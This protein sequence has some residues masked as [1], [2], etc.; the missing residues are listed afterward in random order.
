MSRRMLQNPQELKAIQSR[1]ANVEALMKAGI[2]HDPDTGR[3]YFTGYDYKT[4]YDWDQYFEAI[5]QVYMGW[6]AKYII[7]GITIFL[8]HMREDGLISRS[9]PSN[10]YHDPEHVKPFL[11]QSAVLVRDYYGETSWITDH[12]YQRLK[13]Y[14]DYW[15]VNMD[16]TS[17]GLAEWMS[18]PHTGMDNQHERAGWWKDRISKGVDLNCFLVR[19][20]RAFASLAE[21]LGE[22]ADSAHYSAKADELAQKINDL[23]WCEEDGLYYDMN[24]Q[25]GALTKVKYINNFAALW[26]NVATPERAKRMV[27]EHLMNGEE[28][29]TAWAP[30]VMAK[31][32]PGYSQTTLPNDLGCNWRANTWIPSNYIVYHGLRQYGYDQIATAIAY[33]TEALM[34]KSGSR[35][36]YNSETGEGCGLNPFWGWSVLGYY[37]MYEDGHNQNITSW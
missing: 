19:E 7:N 11:A 5:V 21:S 3:D 24:V 23:L 9:V 30:A 35:E 36:W 32:E 28:F 37:F 20:L 8:D 1:I 6:D 25:T 4:L 29:W 22:P 26:A 17:N 14:L 2:Q 27:Y 13:R 34:Q 12:Y 10:E 31:S 16:S 18:A 33:R 15:L